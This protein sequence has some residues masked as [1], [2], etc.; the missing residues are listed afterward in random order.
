MKWQS[1]V[2]RAVLERQGMRAAAT[3][4]AAVAPNGRMAA[5]AEI[6]PSSTGCGTP[7]PA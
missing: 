7:A 5:T 3:A 2:R 1:R 6:V 4:A